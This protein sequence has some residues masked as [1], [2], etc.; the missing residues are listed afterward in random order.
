M[1]N[2][3]FMIS[4]I[5]VALINKNSS[6]ETYYSNLC[7]ECLNVLADLGFIFGYSKVSSSRVKIFLKYKNN[8]SVIR[9]FHS[10]FRPSNKV[11]FKVRFIKKMLNKNLFSHMVFLTP[12]GVLTDLECVILNVGGIPLFRV[13]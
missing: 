13:T 8:K 6:V 11:Y 4:A 9:N 12:R 3:L 1:K 5:K 10:A 7:I 2:L